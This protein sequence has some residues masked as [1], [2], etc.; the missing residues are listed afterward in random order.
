MNYGEIFLFHSK[1][2]HGTKI[3]EE[4]NT[5]VSFDFRML[6]DSLSRGRKDQSFF[7]DYNNFDNNLEV[8]IMSQKRKAVC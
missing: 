6:L 2:L 1:L 3:N 4:N 5:R 7:V 8:T